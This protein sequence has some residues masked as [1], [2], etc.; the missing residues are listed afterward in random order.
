[1]AARTVL[2]I[3][4]RPGMIIDASVAGASR[5]PLRKRML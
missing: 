2:T 1:M 3:G 5:R 4:A